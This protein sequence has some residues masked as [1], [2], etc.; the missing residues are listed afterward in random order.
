MSVDRSR[1]PVLV[2]LGLWGL[3]SRKAAQAFWVLSM[4]LSAACVLY[5]F[6]DRRFFLGALFGLAS[7]WYY[8]CIR[9]VDQHGS[10]S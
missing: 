2:R 6:V 4:A 1:W 9:W 3:E 10:W 8:L 5:G 7:L